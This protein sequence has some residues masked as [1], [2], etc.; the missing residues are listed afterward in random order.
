MDSLLASSQYSAPAS[1]N[2][3]IVERYYLMPLHRNR[4]RQKCLPVARCC[5][6][7]KYRVSPAPYA[8]STQR[9]R[10]SVAAVSD[11]HGSLCKCPPLGAA[12]YCHGAYGSPD[13][14]TV[15]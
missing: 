12:L 10:N 6:R 13:Q 7:W 4:C 9:I 11:C 2:L 8:R 5:S 1:I 14:P 3:T 15:C